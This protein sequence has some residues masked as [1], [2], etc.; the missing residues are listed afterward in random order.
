MKSFFVTLVVVAF[1]LLCQCMKLVIDMMYS[2]R[3]CRTDTT[4]K[5]HKKV[6]E[7]CEKTT[8]KIDETS[9]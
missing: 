2:D 8:I 1:F 3:E 6:V 5:E 4:M 9:N 7:M